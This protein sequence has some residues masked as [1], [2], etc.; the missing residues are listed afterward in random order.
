MSEQSVM[1]GT[2]ALDDISE[3]VISL[4]RALDFTIRD[5]LGVPLGVPTIKSS[6]RGGICATGLNGNLEKKV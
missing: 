6:R 5:G 4:E 3:A 1:K 2:T